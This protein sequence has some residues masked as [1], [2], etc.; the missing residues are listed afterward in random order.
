M[1]GRRGGCLSYAAGI[2]TR[3]VRAALIPALVGVTLMLNATQPVAAG[4]GQRGTAQDV[5]QADAA[6]DAAPQVQPAA[7]PQ[8]Q[9]AAAATTL[10][11]RF[12]RAISLRDYHTRVV[13]LGTLVLGM[14]S[15]VVGT[16]MLLRKR[17]LIGDVVGHAA[18]PGVCLA[19]LLQQIWQPG[20]ERSLPA[21]IGGAW[22]AA[23]AGAG[24]TVALRRWTRIR[25]DAAQAVVLSVF[26]GA[27]VVLLSIVQ[28]I[29]TGSAAG[30]QNWIYGQA[31]LM[32]ASD[33]QLISAAAILGLV[34]CGLLFKEF[35]ILAFDEKFAASQGWPV[36]LLDLLL[37]GLVVMVAVIGL[38]AVGLLLVVALLILPPAAARF[39][40]DHLLRTTLL[41]GA[42]GGI[43]AFFGVL[44][45]A[46]LARWATGP[47][48]VLVGGVVFGFS[49]LF[50]TQRGLL[51]RY[52][53]QREVRRKVGRA[54]LLRAMY[55]LIEPGLPDDAPQVT[56]LAGVPVR[57]ELLVQK[58][59]W[60]A[61][62]VAG[63]IADAQ[64]RG[65]IAT[66]PADQVSLTTAGA[67]EAFRA[68]RQHRL[69]EL[70]LMQAAHVGLTQVDRSA[71]RI[72]HFLEPDEIDELERRLARQYPELARP[73]PAMPHSP[74]ALPEEQ[75]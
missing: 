48:I 72:E 40:T 32:L 13:L 74:H 8:K 51:P 14:T 41:A 26:F 16:F 54:D 17:A 62:R 23:L 1:S 39:W 2:S 60:K 21:L 20:A 31:G 75:S 55:E 24:C 6:F 25:D 63:L 19:F 67:E 52:W 34:I 29:P 65:L 69:W 42:I 38:Q 33:V 44:P 66:G 22:L 27:G 59:S 50:G 47:S 37:M 12:V 4:A 7:A 70:F 68:A 35:S 61:R 45:S 5:A 36:L 18:L 73:E 10:W 43:T 58:R 49:L 30:L 57:R 56:S 9:A 71:D 28:R 11:Q 15:G 3:A 46:M 64:R 53:L